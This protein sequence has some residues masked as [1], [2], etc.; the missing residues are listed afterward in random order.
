[1][2]DPMKIPAR[3]TPRARE[4]WWNATPGSVRQTRS[5]AIACECRVHYE[6]ATR[7]SVWFQTNYESKIVS[8]IGD[9]RVELVCPNNCN[10]SWLRLKKFCPQKRLQRA[11]WTTDRSVLFHSLLNHP[12]VPRFKTHRPWYET[13]MADGPTQVLDDVPDFGSASTVAKGAWGRLVSLNTKTAMDV[14]LVLDSNT[15]GRAAS[16]DFVYHDQGISGKHCRI[17]REQIGDT[18]PNVWIEDTRFEFCKFIAFQ[19]FQTRSLLFRSS[20]FVCPRL[21]LFNFRAIFLPFI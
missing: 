3:K 21:V 1:M 12:E 20:L 10:W 11:L 6:C 14:D 5:P 7:F 8:S 15:F 2:N 9:V 19:P 16:C 17:W 18:P 13:N 4:T